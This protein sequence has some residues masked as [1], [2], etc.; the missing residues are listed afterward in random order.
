MHE[1]NSAFFFFLEISFFGREGRREEGYQLWRTAA[2]LFSYLKYGF[3]ERGVLVWFP[4]FFSRFFSPLF[5]SFF[6]IQHKKRGIKK[7]T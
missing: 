5:C 1:K 2:A 3:F 7:L 6:C 4:F